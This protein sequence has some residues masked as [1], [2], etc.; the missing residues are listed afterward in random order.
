MFIFNDVCGGKHF[1]FYTGLPEKHEISFAVALI[2]FQLA[3]E[4]K[5]SSFKIVGSAKSLLAFRFQ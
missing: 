1:F 4:L 5:I 2:G 3:F